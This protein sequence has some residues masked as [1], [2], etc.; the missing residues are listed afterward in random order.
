MNTYSEK[1]NISLRHLRAAHAIW[2]QGSFTRAADILGVVPSA[3]S[4]TI[5]QLEELAGAPL[6]SRTGRPILPTPL[7]LSFLQET[8]PLVAGLNGALE[9]LRA[10]GHMMTGSLRIGASPSAISGLIAPAIA[11][12]HQ[13][14]P[15]ITVTLHDD[16]AEHL[17]EKVM[18]G[19]L[20]LAIA[21]RSR[22]TAELHQRLM[23]RD[24]VVLGCRT[25]S[26]VYARGSIPLE[27]IDPAQLIHLDPDT[28]T[29]DLIASAP[30]LGE[31]YRNGPLKA[32]STVA[33][34]CLLRAGVGYALMPLEALQ[35]FNDPV[36][37]YVTVEGL[38][39]ERSLYL[40]S[41][42]HRPTSHLATTFE[43]FLP[44]IDA[45]TGAYL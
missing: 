45:E 18:S 10:R 28:G 7:G 38:R 23:K 33:Q 11:A 20:D 44:K 40:L 21:G 37:S 9:R 42:R 8:T 24:P 5:R 29:A 31:R 16:I 39:L 2:K 30:E 3:L 14:Y 13:V 6:F 1:T 27:E 32:H 34:L 12:F 19:D 17:A 26:R 4:E 36:I 43:S 25:D 22:E 41:P 35:L 15:D